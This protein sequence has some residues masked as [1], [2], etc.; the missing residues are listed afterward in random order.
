M[1][2]ISPY[3]DAPGANIEPPPGCKVTAASFLV[4][5]SSIYANDD[6]FEDY[7]KPFIERVYSRRD[8]LTIASSSPLSF[9]SHWTSPV[10][11]DNLEKL[12][13]PGRADAHAFGERFRKLYAP[14]LP[15]KDLGKKKKHKKGDMK[16]KKGKKPGPIEEPFRVWSASSSR[17]V[18][19]AKAWIQGAFP[20]YQE[21]KD[22]EGDGKY[23]SLV[24]VPKD[25]S[26]WST[27]LTPHKICDKFSKEPGKKEA[28]EWLEKFGPPAVERMNRLAPGFD[29]ELNDVIGAQLFCGYESVILKSRSSPFC[30]TELFTEDEFRAHGYWHDLHWHHSVGYGAAVA[31]YLGIGWLNTT[32]HNLVSAYEEPHPHP[33]TTDP[34]PPSSRFSLSSVVSILSGK[35]LPPPS[36][37]PDATHT[38]LLFPYFTHREEPPFALVALGLWNTTTADLPTDRMPPHRVWKTSH[39]LPF[40]GHVAIERIGCDGEH[41]DPRKDYIRV[42][43]NGAPQQLPTCHDGPGGSCALGDFEK[44][45]A[46]RVEQYKDFV[47]ACKE[48]EE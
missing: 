14:L 47:G 42:L 21:G 46:D 7:M 12:T 9:L 33:N 45:V 23:I 5:H 27:A 2:G 17:D 40:L 44:F 29:F 20:K 26:D 36:A 16:G 41:D 43:V 6:E 35:K 37:P 4:R 30:S 31:P 19:T 24:K 10:T 28:Q 11:E 39:V 32:T 1:S 22:G 38:Q 15:P 34:A 8:N 25:E 48:D 18:E 3:H 13:E